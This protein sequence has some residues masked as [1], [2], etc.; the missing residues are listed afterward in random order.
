MN[1]KEF[2]KPT[3][4]KILISIIG[5]IIFTIVLNVLIF[6]C[7]FGSCNKTL[8]NTIEFIFLRPLS[9]LVTD[10]IFLNMLTI[11]IY[12]LLLIYLVASLIISVRKRK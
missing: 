6:G 4:T 11:L 3:K 10:S 2:I 8:E 9:L 7:G 12:Y 5:S 1:F